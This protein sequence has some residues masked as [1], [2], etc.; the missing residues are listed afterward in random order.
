[1]RQIGKAVLT[2]AAVTWLAVPT[3]DAQNWSF[4]ARRVALGGVGSE[5]NLASQMMAEEREYRA[6]VLPLGLVQVVRNRNVFD[7]GSDQFDLVRSIE[8]AASPFH[9]TTY[10]SQH[11]AGSRFVTDLRNGRLSRDLNDYRGFVPAHQPAA[12]GLAAPGYGITIPVYRSRD[13]Y[14]GLYV[15]AGPYLAMRGALALD[16]QLIDIWSSPVDVY[17]P[18]AELQLGTSLRGQFGMAVTGGYRARVAAFGGRGD[19]DGLYLAANY[20][21]LRGFRYEDADF[22]L[23]F[24]TDHDG[25]VSDDGTAPV[26]L[27]VTRDTASRGH[28]FAMDL[29]AGVVID[30]W[31]VGFGANGVTNRIDWRDVRRMHY[32]LESLLV[33]QSFTRSA[34]EAH[35]DRRVTL[36]V[37]YLGNVGYHADRWSAMAE[38]G[39]GLQGTSLHGGLEYRLGLLEPRV[40]MYYARE[41]WQPSAG[42]GLQFAPRVALDMAVYSTDANVQR[43]RQAAFATSLRIG[44]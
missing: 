21:Y 20:H 18:N 43:K 9:Y 4:D 38:A 34:P 17:L 11:A 3:A 30:R 6:I 12:Q 15:G 2:A 28:G 44:R 40:G 39:R 19:R 22:D 13:S 8:S 32:S 29:G 36:P 31:E 10:P 37:E 16:Q 41:R 25:M 27:L 14:Q 35:G 24:R 23:R 7:P 42:V 26:P 33:E 1:V 5:R